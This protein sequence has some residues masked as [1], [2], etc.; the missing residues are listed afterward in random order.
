MD[1]SPNPSESPQV[2]HP[3]VQSIEDVISF[4]LARLVGINERAG[5]RW[6][7][8]MFGISL[9]EWRVLALIQGYQPMRAGDLADLMLMDKSQLSRVT[10]SVQDKALVKSRPDSRDARAVVLSLSAKG[11]RL[12]TNMLAEVLRRNENVLRPLSGQE[13]LVLNDLLER[14][15]AHNLTLLQAPAVLPE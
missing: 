13:V 11:Q 1:Q 6:S 10:K 15:I 12:Y 8:V 7:D 2:K 3:P 9:N 4:R 14:L 5:Q